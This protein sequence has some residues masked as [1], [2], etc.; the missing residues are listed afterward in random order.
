MSITAELNSAFKASTNPCPDC[1]DF[2]TKVWFEHQFAH[3]TPCFVLLS[4]VANCSGGG[5]SPC[6]RGMNSDI[7]TGADRATCLYGST[8]VQRIRLVQT[9]RHRMHENQLFRAC[10]CEPCLSVQGVHGLMP[11][12][13]WCRHWWMFACLRSQLLGPH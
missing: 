2:E 11:D 7:Q 5:S 3:L 4:T 9:F 1:S 6:W 10:G 8:A 12:C 13:D